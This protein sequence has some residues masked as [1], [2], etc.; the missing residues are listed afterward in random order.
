MF[1]IALITHILAAFLAYE[2]IQISPIIGWAYGIWVALAT[3]FIIYI[4]IFGLLGR[5]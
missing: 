2:I 3:S 1:V 4:N 5:G